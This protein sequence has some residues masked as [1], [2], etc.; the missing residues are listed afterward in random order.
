M[1]SELRTL[2]ATRTGQADR[3]EKY[4]SAKRGYSAREGGVSTYS[5]GDPSVYAFEEGFGAHEWE[6]GVFL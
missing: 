1:F 5:C 3:D 6:E 4:E 2:Q